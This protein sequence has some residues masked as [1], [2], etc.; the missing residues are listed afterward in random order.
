MSVDLG[1]TTVVPR[2]LLIL[3]DDEMVGILIETIGGLSGMATR[4]V[5]DHEAFF[6]AFVA[7]RPSHVVVDLTMPG[8]PGEDV[9][10]ELAALA[11]M[12]RVV[13]CS[14]SEPERLATAAAL[15]TSLGLT[16]VG[17]LPKPFPMAAMRQ[18]LA[19]Q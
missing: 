4:R 13:V 1:H 15:A 12:A 14:G 9:L 7:E 6:A 16:C 10:R 19:A 17:V 5:L 18:A 8:M 3:D 2:S 11:C